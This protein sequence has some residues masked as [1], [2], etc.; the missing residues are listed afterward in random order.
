MGSSSVKVPT[1]YDWNFSS[2]LRVRLQVH[3]PQQNHHGRRRV[4]NVLQ[5]VL[6][7]LDHVF[8]ADT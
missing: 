7:V 6:D 8:T 5:F 2:N 4:T 1:G 3:L